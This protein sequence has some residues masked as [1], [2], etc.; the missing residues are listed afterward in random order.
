MAS[1][2]GAY[3]AKTKLAQLLG[4]VAKGNEVII[5]RHEKPVARLSAVVP[6]RKLSRADA[7][8][9][10]DALAASVK[11]GRESARDL[12]NAGRRS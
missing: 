2:V 4:K 12:I 10:L 11:P 9:R 8:Q 3:E 1:E 7:L 5:T 6:R